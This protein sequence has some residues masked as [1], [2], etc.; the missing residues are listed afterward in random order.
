MKIAP[1]FIRGRLDGFQVL[2]FYLFNMHILKK[3]SAKSLT[4]EIQ[5]LRYCLSVDLVLI[6]RLALYLVS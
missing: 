5:T 6:A 4:F 3:K 2:S 1:L